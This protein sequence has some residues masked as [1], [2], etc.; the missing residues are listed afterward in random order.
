MLTIL[1]F[2][3]LGFASTVDAQERLTKFRFVHLEANGS[4]AVP[5]IAKEARFSKRTVWMWR[6]FASAA[7][8]G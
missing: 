1:I 4:Q 5:F 7:A 2:A 6:S 3:V 8:R